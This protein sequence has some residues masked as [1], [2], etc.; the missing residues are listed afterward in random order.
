MDKGNGGEKG[1]E[2]SGRIRYS[3]EG[4]VALCIIWSPSL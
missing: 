4:N 2:F 1:R 3:G